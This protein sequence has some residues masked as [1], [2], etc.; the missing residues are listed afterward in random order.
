MGKARRRGR[1]IAMQALYCWQINPTENTPSLE[2]SWVNGD[3]DDTLSKQ[4]IQFARLLISGVYA[5]LDEIDASIERIAKNW[6]IKRLLEIDKALLRIGIFSLR[7]LHDI[8]VAVTINEAIEIAKRFSD[9]KST[10]FL[11]GILDTIAKKEHG[12]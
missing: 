5:H 6:S 9:H 12:D 2:F 4:A 8:P 7:Y 1:E 10:Q 11:N 3:K